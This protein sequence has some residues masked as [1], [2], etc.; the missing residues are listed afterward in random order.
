MTLLKTL[1]A[2]YEEISSK[3]DFMTAQLQI[4]R[5]KLSPNEAETMLRPVGMPAFKLKTEDSFMEFENYLL[6]DENFK[7]AV[8]F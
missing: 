1:T 3:V 4:V 2:Q 5:K 6:S 8:S 7:L